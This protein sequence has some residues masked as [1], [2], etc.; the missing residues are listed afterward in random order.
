MDTYIRVLVITQVFVLAQAIRG[1]AVLNNDLPQ[2]FAKND[3][4]VRTT[5]SE[6]DASSFCAFKPNTTSEVQINENHSNAN[7]SCEC[8]S[9]ASD[10]VVWKNEHCDDFENNIFQVVDSK[11]VIVKPA[12]ANKVVIF[13]QENNCTKKITIK[14]IVTRTSPGL[15]IFIIFLF[16][17]LLILIIV[18]VAKRYK[19]HI[20]LS[21]RD[22][23]SG[24]KGNDEKEFDAY[25]SMG[26][27]ESDQKFV[28]RNII[29]ILR[30]RHNYNFYVDNE[31][32][33]PRLEYSGK[34]KE[35]MQKC[36]R[37]LIVFTAAYMTNEWCMYCFSEGLRKLLDLHVPMIF[38]A[39]DISIQRELNSFADLVGHIPQVYLPLIQTKSENEKSVRKIRVHMP[40][41]CRTSSSVQSI[42]APMLLN[43]EDIDQQSIHPENDS[44]STK[45]T[46]GKAPESH[47][48]D[49][50]HKKLEVDANVALEFD[51][52]EDP[53]AIKVNRYHARKDFLHITLVDDA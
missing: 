23:C 22:S 8:L 52:D 7:I 39:S 53:N 1:N 49:D 37:L 2:Y 6:K 42:K 32:L 29:D 28:Q 17:S 38:V 45:Y 12:A 3:V 14:I 31:N 20:Y 30:K 46:F 27:S 33:L 41:A 24:S 16:V 36:S 43:A 9:K 15:Q 48:T 11:L 25:I 13:C 4:A 26:K 10:Q 35:K 21:I 44:H 5:R 18:F 40:A 51:D 50:L 19:S 47:K 34:V